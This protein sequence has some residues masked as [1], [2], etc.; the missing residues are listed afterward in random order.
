MQL[1]AKAKAKDFC[2]W[3][4]LKVD[5]SPRCPHPCLLLFTAC[6]PSASVI[7]SRYFTSVDKY[8]RSFSA[9][10]SYPG[11]GIFIHWSTNIADAG[12]V[13]VAEMSICS[14]FEFDTY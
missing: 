1:E 7:V 9:S 12:T 8:T 10:V 2:P 11:T 5:D 6:D 4:V 14:T 13:S 3:G